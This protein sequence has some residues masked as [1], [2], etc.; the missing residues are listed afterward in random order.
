MQPELTQTRFETTSWSDLKLLAETDQT[1]RDG[2]LNTL[3]IRYWP[4]V[5]AHLRSQGY[6]AAQASDLTQEFFSQVI[7]GRKLFERAHEDKGRLRN[8]LLTAL[9]NFCID[10]A[11]RQRLQPVTRPLDHADLL[12]E[13]ASLQVMFDQQSDSANAYDRRW[14]LSLFEESIRRCKSHFQANG[15]SGHWT[16]F[17]KRILEPASSGNRPRPIADLCGQ[18]GFKNPANAVAAIQVVKK[19]LASILGDVVRETVDNE[20]F[21]YELAAVRQLI[22]DGQSAATNR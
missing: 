17:A 16:M 13:E 4:P 5:Y 10:Q 1:Q 22:A 7:L 12:A 9:K 21:E 3:S 19:R 11:R 6:D 8:F 18:A 15:R 14:A 20:E 2:I